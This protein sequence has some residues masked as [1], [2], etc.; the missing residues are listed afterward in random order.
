MAGKSAEHLLHEFR[1]SASADVTMALLRSRDAMFYLALMAAH[2]GDGQ[3]VDGQTLAAEIDADLPALLRSYFP[4]EGEG[5]AWSSDADAL[6]TRWTK[7][8]WVHRSVDS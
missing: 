2:L 6:L 8:G 3:I 7:K 1:A 4:A 5:A